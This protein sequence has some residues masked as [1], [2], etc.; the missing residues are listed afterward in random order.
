MEKI[1]GKNIR[2]VLYKSNNKYF[3]TEKEALTAR[4]EIWDKFMQE[5]DCKQVTLKSEIR[6]K[7]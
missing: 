6:A 3:K 4:H 5:E 2:K 1:D 7:I